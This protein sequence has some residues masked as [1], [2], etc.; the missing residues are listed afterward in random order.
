MT[1]ALVITIAPN[2]PKFGSHHRERNIR[3]NIDCMPVFK[4]VKV[5]SDFVE[6]CKRLNAAGVHYSV[7]IQLFDQEDNLIQRIPQAPPSPNI[8]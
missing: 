1:N 5:T 2:Q 6:W 8:N 3:F 4:N 7:S